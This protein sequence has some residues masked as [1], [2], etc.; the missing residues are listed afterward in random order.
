MT[1]K[2]SLKRD[3]GRFD[4]DN[5]EVPFRMSDRIFIAGLGLKVNVILWTTLLVAGLV[6]AGMAI[7]FL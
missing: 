7:R 6:G 4:P 5:P 1:R 2:E 3:E